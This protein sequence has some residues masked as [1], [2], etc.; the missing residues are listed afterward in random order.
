MRMPMIIA[1]TMALSALAGCGERKPQEAAAPAATTPAA[2][3]P[4]DA[5]P[6]VDTAATDATAAPATDAAAATTADPATASGEL[7]PAD[8]QHVNTPPG[9]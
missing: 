4:A 6:A 9:R 3:A 2:T 5:A 1:A 8:V 7:P